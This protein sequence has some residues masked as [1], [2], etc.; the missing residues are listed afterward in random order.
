MAALVGERFAHTGLVEVLHSDV[1]VLHKT[2][3]TENV[4]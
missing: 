2:Y 4:Y 3:I 1:H